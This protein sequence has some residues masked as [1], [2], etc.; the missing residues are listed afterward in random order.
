MVTLHLWQR[1]VQRS[2][3]RGAGQDLGCRPLSEL[4]GRV[5]GLQNL[6]VGEA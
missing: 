1:A 3:F 4:I 5:R 6:N 2:G